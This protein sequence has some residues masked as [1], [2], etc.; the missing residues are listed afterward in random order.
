M[1]FRSLNSISLLVARVT[2]PFAQLELD[3]PSC[4]AGTSLF[5]FAYNVHRLCAARLR[6]RAPRLPHERDDDDDGERDDDTDECDDDTDECDANERDDVRQARRRRQRRAPRKS[7]TRATKC[8]HERDDADQREDAASATTSTRASRLQKYE[9]GTLL[10]V[11]H[12]LQMKLRPLSTKRKKVFTYARHSLHRIGPSFP[13][14]RS[15]GG[16]SAGACSA[17][18]WM[19]APMQSLVCSTR[20]FSLAM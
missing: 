8:M 11:S 1:V 13:K 15:G 5:A 6:R 18:G 9:S 17:S 14:S 2:S 12:M 3:L 7:H 16:Y 19:M 20:S 4:S 10:D